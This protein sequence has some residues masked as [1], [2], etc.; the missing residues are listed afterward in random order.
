MKMRSVMAMMRMMMRMMMMNKCEEEGED[1]NQH[2]AMVC[3]IPLI[4]TSMATNINEIE[5]SQP[6]AGQLISYIQHWHHPKVEG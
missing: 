3:V 1:N 6:A 2:Y 4:P 5:W